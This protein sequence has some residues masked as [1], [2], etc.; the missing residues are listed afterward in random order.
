M[1][2]ISEVSMT[3]FIFFDTLLFSN[4]PASMETCLVT[5]G[6]FLCGCQGDG[7]A[8]WLP[9]GELCPEGVVHP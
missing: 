9:D 8:E 6:F 3:R 1:Y 4:K 5:D 7:K 2:S